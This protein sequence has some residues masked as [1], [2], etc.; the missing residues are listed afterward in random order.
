MAS[1]A[2]QQGQYLAYIHYY[3]KLNGRPP[4][5]ADMQ[6]YF[7]TTPPTVHSMVI[8]LHKLGLIERQAGTPRSLRV[9]VPVD[10]LPK[11]D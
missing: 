9:T 3:T 11:L 1:Y 4:A 5:E 6:Q 10:E 8:R 2:Y 7:R